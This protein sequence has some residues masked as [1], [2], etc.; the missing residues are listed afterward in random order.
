MG[1][2]IPNASSPLASVLDQ[3]EPDS[4]DFVALGNRKTGVVSGCTVTAQPSPDTNVTVASGEVISNGVYHI[5][6][7][8]TVDLTA[9][10]AGS[11][12]FDI[13]VVD[14]SGT[15]QKRLGTSTAGVNPTFADLQDGDV[16]LA[17]VY[18]AAGTSD[19][20]TTSRIIDKRI[21]VTSNTARS[22]SGAPSTGSV[23]DTY[24]NTTVSDV[25]GQSQYYVKTTSGSWENLAEFTY[26]SIRAVTGS[27][28]TL[29]ITDINNFVEYSTANVTVSIPTSSN[30]NFAVGSTIHLV[31]AGTSTV[32]VASGGSNVTVNSSLGRNLRAQWS[33]ASLVKRSDGSWLLFGDLTT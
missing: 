14:S 12:R 31:R 2:I 9:G 10:T 4:G 3:S 8:E 18:R 6:N 32:T 19:I 29:Q 1:Y 33:T 5:V 16:F 7:G 26:P 22:G 28:D 15:V 11:A 20:V 21:F 24:V 23:G 17:A 27:S 13:V 25:A 30:S